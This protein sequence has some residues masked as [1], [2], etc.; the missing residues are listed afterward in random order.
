MKLLT[1]LNGYKSYLAGA[2]LL[3][4]ALGELLT[5][6]G[7]CLTLEIEPGACFEQ[8]PRLWDALSSAAIGI[9]IIGVRH[10]V[11]KNGVGQ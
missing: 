4:I 3:L 5:H 10:S 7:R 1:F 2:G 6:G 9:G 8:F 11:A